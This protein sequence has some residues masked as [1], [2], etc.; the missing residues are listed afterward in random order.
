MFALQ[1]DEQG[2]W[3]DSPILVESVGTHDGPQTAEDDE[4][5]ASIGRL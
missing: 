2:N 5:F 3:L 4:V 1:Y